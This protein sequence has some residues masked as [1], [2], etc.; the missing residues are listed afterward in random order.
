MSRPN[1]KR[2][3]LLAA[4]FL[5]PVLLAACPK[6]DPPSRPR[7]SVSTSPRQPSVTTPVVVAFNGERAMDHVRK[8]IDF[9]PRPPDTP[10]L[11]RTRAY[12]VK[13]LKSSGLNVYLDEFNATTPQ[14]EKKMANIVGEI[15]GETKTL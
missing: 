8:Q 3:S 6:N 11:A 2:A 10:Q 1:V 12:I 4:V 7:A 5:M 14:G 9:G 13:E 15:S